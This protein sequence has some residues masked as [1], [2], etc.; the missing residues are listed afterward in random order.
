[1][2][3]AE[4]A[5]HLTGPVPAEAQALAQALAGNAEAVGFGSVAQLAGELAQ[6]LGRSAL[7][8]GY[9]QADGQLFVKASEDIRYLL[10]Q[11]AAGFLRAH[12]AALLASLQAYPAAL[13]AAL[14]AGKVLI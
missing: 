14:P 2:T 13:E 5:S 1:M 7:A 10:H 9:S 6:A 3:L 8:E 11:F 4:W 12:D